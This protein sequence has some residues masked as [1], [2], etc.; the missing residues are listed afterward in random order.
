[1][2]LY[3]ITLTNGN[4]FIVKS[5]NM[6]NRILEE[7]EIYEWNDY[8]LAEKTIM[9]VGDKAVKNNIVMVKSDTIA[10]VECYVSNPTF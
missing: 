4:M 8:L 7:I 2:Y 5:K 1:M 9:Y 3:K 6:I 10:S